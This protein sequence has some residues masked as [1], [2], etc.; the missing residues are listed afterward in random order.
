VTLAGPLVRAPRAATPRVAVWTS[1]VCRFGLAGVWLWAGLAKVLNADEAVRAVAAYRLL[2]HVMVKPFA[3]GLP[4]AELALAVLHLL[5]IRPRVAALVT[6]V[7]LIL[8]VAAVGSAW[9]RGL[10]IDCGCFG[11]GG[12]SA[13]AG[14]RTYLLEIARDLGF[15]TLAVWLVVRPRSHLAM[16]GA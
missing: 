1:T 9:A 11:G 15:A 4:F 12:A 16:E 8:F 6:W 7:L 5:G 14:W 10:R 2:P 3:W 13:A